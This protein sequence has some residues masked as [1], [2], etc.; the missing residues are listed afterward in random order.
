LRVPAA[1]VPGADVLGLSVG[2]MEGWNHR[3]ARSS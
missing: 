1:V 2:D 3:T